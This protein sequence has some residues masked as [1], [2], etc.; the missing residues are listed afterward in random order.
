MEG[1]TGYEPMGVPAPSISKETRRSIIERVRENLRGMATTGEN[2]ATPAAAEERIRREV[3]NVVARMRDVIGDVAP[4]E[5]AALQKEAADGFLRLG[6]LQ[7]LQ[8]DDSIS[9]I[10][11]NGGGMDADGNFYAPKVFVEVDG[12][13]S[14]RPDIEIS[15]VAELEALIARIGDRMGRRCDMAN[16]RMDA[17]L[18]DG[19]RVNATHRSISLDG[20]SLTI[21]K[22]RKDAMTPEELVDRGTCTDDMMMFLSSCIASRL[23]IFISGGTGSGKTTL[24]NVLSSFVPPAERIVSIEDTAELQLKQP[25]I[26]RLQA[27]PANTEGRGAITI[28]DLLVNALRMRPDRI[29]VGECRSTETLEMLQAM[30]TGHD[31]SLTTVHANSARDAVTRI[32][33]MALQAEGNLTQAAIDAQIASAAQLIVHTSRFPSGARRIESICS[34]E[35]Y[36]EGRVVLQELFKWEGPDDPSRGRFVATGFT[37]EKIRGKI[38]GAGYMYR[39]EWFLAPG[40]RRGL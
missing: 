35:G 9:E 15:S 32:G 3:A 2:A 27:R 40:G 26:V 22:F 1:F 19:S 17:S 34:I 8:E 12:V 37:S 6:P 29:I 28:H 18:P 20:P 16:P 38:V 24:L 13:I 23:N 30:N 31:G 5:L 14:P 39:Q 7:P 10:M 11:V 36:Q 4:A 33:T 25:N 21:R